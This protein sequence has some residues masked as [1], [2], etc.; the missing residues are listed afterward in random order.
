M[1]DIDPTY[2]K[3]L[4]WILENDIK[5]L[6]LTF[7]YELEKLGRI[8]VVDLI[9]NGR[10]TQVNEE[11]KHEYVQKICYAKMALEIQDQIKNFLLGF[12]EIVPS[13]L[14]QIFDS[15]ELELMLSGLPEIDSN[16]VI[17]I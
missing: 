3:N 1:E 8:E 10:N 6:D 13:S 12:S 5:D 15:M 4:K 11:N 16:T 17:L 9:K 14:V 7:S 2:F